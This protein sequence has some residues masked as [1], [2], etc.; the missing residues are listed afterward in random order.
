MVTTQVSARYQPEPDDEVM[1][2][3]LVDHREDPLEALGTMLMA[4]PAVPERETL[5]S[6][7]ANFV[8]PVNTR[9]PSTKWSQ[10]L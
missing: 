2:T 4:A 5:T 9:P 7:I 6:L 10:V 3:L 8:L 1:F